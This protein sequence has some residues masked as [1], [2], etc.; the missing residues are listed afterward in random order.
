ME[1]HLYSEVKSNAAELVSSALLKDGC[2]LIRGADIGSAEAFERCF[3]ELMPSARLMAYEGERASPRS[4]VAGGVYTSTEYDN[5]AS[6]FIHNEMSSRLSWPL[7][8]CFACNLPAD[9]GGATPLCDIRAVTSRLPR[10]ISDEFTRRGI[11]YMRNYGAEYGVSLEYAFGTTDKKTIEDYCR[12][13]GIDLEWVTD[14]HLRTYFSRSA[15][16]HHPKTDERLWFNYST[17]YSLAS[18]GRRQRLMLKG[19]PEKDRAFSASYADGEAIPNHVFETL[20]MLY[21]EAT[22]RFD[23]QK[24]DMVFLDNMLIGHGRDPYE[25]ERRIWLLMADEVARRDAMGESLKEGVSNAEV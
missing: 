21:Q 7:H 9:Q 6:I 24:G 5:S 16:V 1:V 13:A 18:L 3:A 17:F 15:F 20:A 12:N 22:F 19:V 10:E 14:S 23:W 4:A 8:M 2:I 25:G 11:R